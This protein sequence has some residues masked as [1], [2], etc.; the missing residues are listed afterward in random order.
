MRIL[1]FILIYVEA[2]RNEKGLFYPKMFDYKIIEDFLMKNFR[3]NFTKVQ[4]FIK[5]NTILIQFH[6]QK[7]Q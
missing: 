3:A 1:S 5:A 2:T 6:S 4:K 7:M